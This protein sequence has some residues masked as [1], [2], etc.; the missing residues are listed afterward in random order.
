MATG[1]NGSRE[2]ESRMRVPA[3]G[4]RIQNPTGELKV[5]CNSSLGDYMIKVRACS[6][7]VGDDG[8][9]GND[10]TH[11]GEDSCASISFVRTRIDTMTMHALI[12]AE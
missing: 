6:G 11:V 5:V 8:G 7:E 4:N 12:A 2:W 10:L 9:G 3:G 1:K